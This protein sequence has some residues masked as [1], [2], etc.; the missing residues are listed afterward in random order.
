MNEAVE[1]AGGAMPT[2]QRE[3]TF[4]DGVPAAR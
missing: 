3:I 2:P 4:P 1:R